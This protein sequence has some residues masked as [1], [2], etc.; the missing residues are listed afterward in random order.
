MKRTLIATALALATLFITS[1]APKGLGPQ[2]TVVYN[3]NEV[4]ERVG[5]LQTAVIKAS[6]AKAIPTDVAREIVTFTVAANKTIGEVPNG[7]YPT[8][9][10]AWAALQSKV[11]AAIR[12]NPL[13][14][15][16]WVAVDTII[17]VLKQPGM[18]PG[19]EPAYE[20]GVR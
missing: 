12:D 7:W 20:G 19:L 17:A 14:A 5:R 3:A 1:C 6:D 15:T 8:V 2:E 4:V 16:A 10:A 13:I 18:P 9:K 11:P